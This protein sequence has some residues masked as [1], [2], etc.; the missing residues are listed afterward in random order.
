[1]LR[2]ENVGLGLEEEAEKGILERRGIK[3]ISAY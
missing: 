3:S 2:R 1:M